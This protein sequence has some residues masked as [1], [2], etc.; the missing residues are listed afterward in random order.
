MCLVSVKALKV[1]CIAHLSN[2]LAGLRCDVTTGRQ[3]CEK[4]LTFVWVTAGPATS[5]SAVVP[6]ER[7][8][9][10]EL[11]SSPSSTAP[12]QSRRGQ[13]HAPSTA[14]PH[15]IDYL[16][17]ST[18]PSGGRRSLTMV[19]TFSAACIC[20]VV[21]IPMFADGNVLRIL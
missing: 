21:R 2:W 11:S 4:C 16:P 1:S 17:S 7:I 18:W 5:R 13:R 9:F 12:L 3:S 14:R 20:H 6:F 19:G 8:D 15:M 10:G